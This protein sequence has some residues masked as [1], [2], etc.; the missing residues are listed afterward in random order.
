VLLVRYEL[1]LS[2]LFRR[3]SIFEVLNVKI[4]DT[5]GHQRALN[6]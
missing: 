2:M 1:N 3:N 6:V 5:Y 4:D